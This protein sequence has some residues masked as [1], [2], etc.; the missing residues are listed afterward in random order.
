MPPSPCVSCSMMCTYLSNKCHVYLTDELPLRLLGSCPQLRISLIFSFLLV[1]NVLLFQAS[2]L[3][4][5]CKNTS[6]SLTFVF[7][8]QGIVRK[9]LKR[10]MVYMKNKIDS[11]SWIIEWHTTTWKI[12]GCYSLY[13]HLILQWNFFFLHNIKAGCL[14]FC[15]KFKDY[16][17]STTLKCV[18]YAFGLSMVTRRIN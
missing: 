8:G 17:C 1:C 12:L 14:V 13:C 2:L 3:I 15:L 5:C 16:M 11:T 10:K 18:F 7:R 9:S 6:L 4:W